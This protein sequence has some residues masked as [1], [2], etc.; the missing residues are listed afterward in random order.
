MDYQPNKKDDPE[1][2]E[3]F[4]LLQKAEYLCKELDREK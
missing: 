3:M 1:K 2:S 4:T